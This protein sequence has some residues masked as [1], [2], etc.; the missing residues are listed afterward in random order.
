MPTDSSFSNPGGSG[1]I[2][3][4]LPVSY[5]A[6]LT[7]VMAVTAA[8]VGLG[9]SNGTVDVGNVDSDPV[10]VDGVGVDTVHCLNCSGGAPPPEYN[11]FVSDSIYA[12]CI[13]REI[14]AICAAYPYRPRAAGGTGWANSSANLSV[15]TNQWGRYIWPK[16]A[17]SWKFIRV[18]AS[19]YTPNM[20]QSN[21]F[22]CTVDAFNEVQPVP[23]WDGSFPIPSDPCLP[24]VWST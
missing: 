19:G 12:R 10:P 24:I 2:P 20:F 15:L 6:L 23:T 4:P 21:T 7:A 17:S 9:I 13:P 14:G 16:S 18:H 22:Y 1:S 3:N 8:V 11:G 5:P